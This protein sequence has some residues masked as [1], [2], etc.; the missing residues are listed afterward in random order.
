M[1]TTA[2]MLICM[3]LPVAGA[4]A[5]PGGYNPFPADTRPAPFELR[6]LYSGGLLRIAD[7]E[8]RTVA[9]TDDV[10]G[11]K[12]AV[13]LRVDGENEL[14]M[15][16]EENVEGSLAGL[17]IGDAGWALHRLY[18]GD[19]NG[20]QT[21]DYVVLSYGG[22]VGRAASYTPM[23]FVLSVGDGYQAVQTVSYYAKVENFVLLDGKPCFVNVMDVSH[24]A[25]RDGYAHSFYVH[26]LLTFAGGNVQVDNSVHPA[27]PVTQWDQNAIHQDSGA[28]E[29]KESVGSETTLL[30]DEQRARLHG[31]SI[32]EIFSRFGE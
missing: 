12:R 19:Q 23:S 16:L 2:L 22:G 6:P 30:T 18:A 21:D 27:F 5:F 13:R 20:D 24:N 10:D 25:C 28:F 9:F 11:L 17:P 4:L 26:N 8:N 32:R 1:R 15:D 14:H 7:E 3:L 31:E 29:R